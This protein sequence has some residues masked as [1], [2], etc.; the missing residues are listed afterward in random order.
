MLR[1][2]AFKP[3]QSGNPAGSS[4]SQRFQAAIERAFTDHDVTELA[5][6]LKRAAITG[7]PLARRLVVDRLWP[8]RIEHQHGGRI[9]VTTEMREVVAGRLLRWVDAARREG[10]A[11]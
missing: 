10:G 7:D 8:Q 9:E 2:H 1:E 6:R 4:A 3:G 5:R 11:A